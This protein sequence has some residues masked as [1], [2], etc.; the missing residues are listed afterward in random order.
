MTIYQGF[1]DSAD[2]KSL[3]KRLRRISLIR[4]IGIP[5]YRS[6]ISVK[7]LL[8]S[9]KEQE[10]YSE[11]QISKWMEGRSERFLTNLFLIREQCQRRGIIL[12][13]ANQQAKS[14]VLDEE[15]IKG[16]TYQEEVELLKRKLA[17]QGSLRP[18]ETYL[19]IHSVLMA[20]LE[21]W[22]STN[23]VHFL[24]VIAALDQDRDL[25]SSW[26]HL[27]SKGNRVVADAFAEKI[28]DTER[29]T[30]GR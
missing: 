6:L 30:V 21:L 26:V 29:L 13:V 20:N 14:F 28:L 15:A 10:T 8:A 1:N 9:L 5:L 24:D 23:D 22:A 16:V 11:Q 7:F 4:K 3:K 17:E 19:Y 18:R 27:S 25:L 12:I 2:T